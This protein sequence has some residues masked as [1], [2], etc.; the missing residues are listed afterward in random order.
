[1]EE[2]SFS[3]MSVCPK[4]LLVGTDKL[5]VRLRMPNSFIPSV[6]TSGVVVFTIIM[7]LT[8]TGK[9]MKAIDGL[10]DTVRT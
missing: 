1:M 5:L 10:W 2:L 3:I 8:R 9:S 6:L 7:Y 4:N